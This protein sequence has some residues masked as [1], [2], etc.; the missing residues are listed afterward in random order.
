MLRAHALALLLQMLAVLVSLVNLPAVNTLAANTP[1]SMT[2][3]CTEPLQFGSTGRQIFD[4]S[5]ALDDTT[6][7]WGSPTGTP[8][9]RTPASRRAKGDLANTSKVQLHTHLA[10]HLDAPSHFLQNHLDS[11]RGVEA[12]DLGALNGTN[13]RLISCWHILHQEFAMNI[14]LACSMGSNQIQITSSLWRFQQSKR[15]AHSMHTFQ[16]A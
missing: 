10:T 2:N 14:S 5:K 15:I 8:K 13:R 6:V 11:G 3:V 7:S 1:E 9:L 12:L 16:H 4:I